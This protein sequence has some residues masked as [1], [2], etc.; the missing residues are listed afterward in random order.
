MK[1]EVTINYGSYD[2]MCAEVAD[3]SA[4]G[5]LKDNGGFIAHMTGSDV[6]FDPIQDDSIEAIEAEIAN[7]KQ[8]YKV[9]NVCFVGIY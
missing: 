5:V 9:T 1:Q 8:S 2:A 7:I 6:E 4:I 3:F